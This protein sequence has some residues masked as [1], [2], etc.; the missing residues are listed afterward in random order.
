MPRTKNFP[1]GIKVGMNISRDMNAKLREAAY[2][3]GADTGV[4]VDTLIREHIADYIQQVGVQQPLPAVPV[5]P[6]RSRQ[7]PAQQGHAL[8]PRVS[9]IPST[10]KP[11]RAP[12]P[13]VST[14]A[15]ARAD[16]RLAAAAAAS[17]GTHWTPDTLQVVLD[18][19]GVRRS[20]LRDAMGLT[21]IDMWWSPG[22]GKTPGVPPGRW[23]QIDAVL[24]GLGWMP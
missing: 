7:Q 9:T 12:S 6:A 10:P 2:V 13:E 21:N 5:I 4:I 16:A 1:D 19:L 8:T 11:K 22:K 20:T 15:R 24:K 3:T 23:E 18:R 17:T 14:A